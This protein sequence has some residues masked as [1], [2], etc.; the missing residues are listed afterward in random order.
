MRLAEAL[1]QVALAQKH[2]EIDSYRTVR[3]REGYATIYATYDGEEGVYFR[4]VDWL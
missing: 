2:G 4:E 3:D 1:R